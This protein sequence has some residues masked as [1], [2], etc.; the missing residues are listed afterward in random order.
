[1]SAVAPPAARATIRHMFLAQWLDRRDAPYAIRN[2]RTGLPLATSLE[3]AFDSESRRRGLLGREGLAPGA[4]LVIAPC[5]S[6]HMFFMK[7]PIDVVFV[8]KDGTVLRTVANV[9]P[10]RIALSPRAFAA[11]E[12]AVGSIERS[13]TRAGDVLELVEAVRA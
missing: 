8:R 3:G 4:A 9:R 7:F 5:N 11:I 13:G 1:M 2:A 10:W 12:L 6:I